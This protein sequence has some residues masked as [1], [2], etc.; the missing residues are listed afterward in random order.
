MMYVVDVKTVAADEKMQHLIEERALVALYQLD[1]LVVYRVVLV[2]P[3]LFY[4]KVLVVV[5]VVEENLLAVL[6]K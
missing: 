1:K 3:Y 4:S 6:R 5:A 2:S